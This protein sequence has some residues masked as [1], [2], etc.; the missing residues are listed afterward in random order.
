MDL[1]PASIAGAFAR[2]GAY[3]TERSYR[4]LD[5]ITQLLQ[6]ALLIVIGL[7]I[8]L[9]MLAILVPMTELGGI[10]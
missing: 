3:Y 9:I 7:L 8:G 5:L 10:E 2:M 4:R 6:P 1:K